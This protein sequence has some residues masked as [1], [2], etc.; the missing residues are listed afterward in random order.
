MPGAGDTEAIKK[1]KI[2]AFTGLISSGGENVI[3][4][5]TS[6]TIWYSHVYPIKTPDLRKTSNNNSIEYTSG[7]FL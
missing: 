7:F 2:L 1:S 4:K 6:Y 5:I 3:P